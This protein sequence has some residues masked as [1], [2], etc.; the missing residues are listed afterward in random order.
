MYKL[1]AVT[2]IAAAA[3]VEDFKETADMFKI[4]LKQQEVQGLEHH[5]QKLQ[6]EEQKYQMQMQNS[7][8]GKQ[9]EMEAQALVHTQEFVALAKYVE[10]M[11][12]AGPTPQMKK[13]AELYH[14]QM[15][16]VQK[17]H[18]MLQKYTAHHIEM[19][20][21]EPTQTATVDVDNKLWFEFNKEY[22]K[23]REMEYYAMYKIPEIAKFRAMVTDVRHTAEMKKMTTHW[24]AVTQ[25]EQ[26]QVVVKH[27]AQLIMAAIKCIHM[28][29]EDKAWMSPK[30]SP[31]M[32]EAFHALYLYFVAMGKGDLE[33]MLD[34]MIDGKYE[35]NFVKHV[36]PD[37]G[38]PETLYLY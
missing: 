21:K 22:Y 13:F 23:L 5:A 25:Q 9:F 37:F 12:K 17:A 28:T 16:K 10:A 31:V 15:V 8:H 1:A 6:A 24:T 19:E 3:T 27:Q 35:E 14:A 30:K 29:E 20:G 34:F 4:T 11:K 7:P 36:K 26:H 38:A 33:P 2:A 32:F 18:M